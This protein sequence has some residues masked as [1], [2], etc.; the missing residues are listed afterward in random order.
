MFASPLP[1][2]VHATKRVVKIRLDHPSFPFSV[3]PVIFF[4]FIFVPFSFVIIPSTPCTRRIAIPFFSLAKVVARSLDRSIDGDE[5]AA[6]P[7][8]VS[9]QTI[10]SGIIR[11]INR[12]ESTRSA[13]FGLACVCLCDEALP[14]LTE[15]GL[16]VYILSCDCE[17]GGLDR[18]GLFVLRVHQARLL[19]AKRPLPA[20]RSIIPSYHPTTATT[21]TLPAEAPPGHE[22]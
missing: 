8:H 11:D 21:T 16:S 10:H 20:P 13:S 6:T 18:V 2:L 17:V 3:S 19:K 12:I 9:S 4:I 15:R 7:L 22:P 14:A 1:P 5:P